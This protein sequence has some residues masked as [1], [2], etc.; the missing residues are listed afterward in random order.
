MQSTHAQAIRMENEVGETGIIYVTVPRVATRWV[1]HTCV[2][3][4]QRL[5]ELRRWPH[6]SSK[7]PMVRGG[8]FP[9]SQDRGNSVSTEPVVGKGVISAEPC[10]ALT[11]EGEPKRTGEL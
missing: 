7:V 8:R 5:R 11:K 9:C 2:A 4:P 6:L 10:L 1:S 3:S